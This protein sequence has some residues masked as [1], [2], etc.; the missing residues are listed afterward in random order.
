MDHDHLRDSTPPPF[1]RSRFGLG[2]L[3]LAAVA[4]WFLW[5]EHRAHL[6]GALPYLLLLACPLM[7]V[8][9]HRGHHGHHHGSAAP[10]RPSDRKP[11]GTADPP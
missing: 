3:V 6:L 8:F 4:G 1:W 7:H 2:C 5:A 11:P 10:D 9:M